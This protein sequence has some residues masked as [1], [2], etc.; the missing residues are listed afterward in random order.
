MKTVLLGLAGLF[1]LIGWLIWSIVSTDPAPRTEW[2][3]TSG[4][5]AEVSL[6]QTQ[7]SGLVWTVAL[8][9]DPDRFNVSYVEKIPSLEQ[10]LQAIQTGAQVTLQTVHRERAKALSMANSTIPILV[11]QLDNKVIYDRDD[12][13]SN[14]PTLIGYVAAVFSWMVAISL[15]MML[16]WLSRKS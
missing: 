2:V 7:K 11:L 6:Q 12:Y 16:V 13:R 3:S 10:R 1:A 4:Q 8:V 5:V 15:I 9:N 14:I